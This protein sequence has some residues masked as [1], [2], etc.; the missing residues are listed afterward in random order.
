MTDEPLARDHR[1]IL[2]H[3]VLRAT[4]DDNRTRPQLRISAN[5]ACGKKIELMGSLLICQ[6]LAQAFI[7]CG[8]LCRCRVLLPQLLDFIFEHL[9]LLMYRCNLPHVRRNGL[10]LLS[11]EG[12]RHLK[13]GEHRAHRPRRCRNLKAPACRKE[14]DA[15]EGEQNKEQRPDLT[16]G[17]PCPFESVNHCFNFFE[18]MTTFLSSP[19]FSSVRPVPSPTQESA[20][21]ETSTGIPVSCESSLSRFMRSAPPPVIIMP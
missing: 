5:D 11:D 14:N 13:W 2:P 20:S 9:V 7:L 3:T 21:S 10:D 12:R 19:M 16:S 4:V 1:H 8:I 15:E 17:L 18:D 6:E